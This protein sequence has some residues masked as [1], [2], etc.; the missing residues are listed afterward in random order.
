MIGIGGFFMDMGLQL[1]AREEI[2]GE[3]KSETARKVSRRQQIRMQKRRKKIA[4]RRR[5]RL[6]GCW[7]QKQDE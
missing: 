2:Y 5:R 7:L 4:R 1:D 3:N 6:T